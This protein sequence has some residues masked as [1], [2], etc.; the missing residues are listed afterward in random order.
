MVGK[1]FQPVTESFFHF[2][3]LIDIEGVFLKHGNETDVLKIF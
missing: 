1:G 2:Q 3:H